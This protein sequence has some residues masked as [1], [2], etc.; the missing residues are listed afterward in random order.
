[1]G[2]P[3]T[4]ALAATAAAG[5]GLKMYG[6]AQAATAQ[7][8]QL[9]DMELESRLDALRTRQHTAR[10]SERLARRNRRIKGSARAEV[11]ASGFEAVGS[12][13]DALTENAFEL[14]LDAANVRIAGRQA[15]RKLDEQASRFG[16]ARKN[17]IRQARL[18]VASE[19]LNTGA[20]IGGYFT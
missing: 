9:E 12:K 3:L 2:D 11:A 17:T 8:D 1:M 6:Q 13:L 18:S 10:E 19:L 4:L 16:D 20:K 7:A 15:A 5:G 14:E